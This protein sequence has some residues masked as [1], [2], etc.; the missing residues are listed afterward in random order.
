MLHILL[1][2][3]KTLVDHLMFIKNI[4]LPFLFFAQFLK[5]EFYYPKLMIFRQ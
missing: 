4:L 3:N 5:P 1:L 2:H